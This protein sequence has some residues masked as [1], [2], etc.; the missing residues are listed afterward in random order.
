MYRSVY[1]HVQSKYQYISLV[2][3]Q[4]KF[5]VLIVRYGNEVDIL[6]DVFLQAS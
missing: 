5:K 3:T 6:I 1:I 4:T 2:I